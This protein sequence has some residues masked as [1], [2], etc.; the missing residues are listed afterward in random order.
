[1]VNPDR[2]QARTLGLP[3][4]WLFPVLFVPFVAILSLSIF[5]SQRDS[6]T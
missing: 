4:S 2:V 5:E 6:V 3:N 1:M